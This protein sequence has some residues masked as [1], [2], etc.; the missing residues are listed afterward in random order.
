MGNTLKLL[1]L[2][3]Q[4]RS[5]YVKVMDDLGIGLSG[6]R[7]QRLFDKLQLCCKGFQ[8]HRRMLLHEVSH[9]F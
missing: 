6:E 4:S 7:E 1:G 9:G 5:K 8:G 3:F 2:R